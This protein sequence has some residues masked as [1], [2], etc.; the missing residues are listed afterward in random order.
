MRIAE[1]SSRSGTSIPSIKFYLRERLLPPGEAIGRNRTE[2]DEGHLHRLRLIRALIDVGRVS[3]ANAREVLTAVD[4]PD[5]PVHD[6]LDAACHSLNPPSRRDT[7][8]PAWREARADVVTLIRE[9]GWMVD[10]ASPELDQ[11]ADAISALRAL[12]HE[13]LLEMLPIYVDVLKRVAV[14]EVDLLVSRAEPAR[15]VEGFIAGTVFGEA[16][17]NAL[18]RLAQ[19]DASARR[20]VSNPG[21]ALA[22]PDGGC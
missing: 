6:L 9:A 7:T 18:R 21:T 17:L 16:L 19:H 12:D 3:V 14:Q 4:T 1:L 2:Y 10:D 13:D 8:D 11:A 5:L 15:T 22:G 20:N